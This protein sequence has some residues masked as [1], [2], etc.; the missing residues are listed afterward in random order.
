M[1]SK[2]DETRKLLCLSLLMAGGTVLHAVESRLPALGTLPGAKLGLGNIVTMLT[3]MSYSLAD[4]WK[5][6]GYCIHICT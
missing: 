2:G 1:N 5:V 6:V 4:T 3:L